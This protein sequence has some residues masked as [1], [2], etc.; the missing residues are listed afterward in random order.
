MRLNSSESPRVTGSRNA[1]AS[2]APVSSS[3]KTPLAVIT[4]AWIFTKAV[5]AISG[6]LAFGGWAE[7]VGAEVVAGDAACSLDGQDM[8][9]RDISPPSPI[10]DYVLRNADGRG[11]LSDAASCFDRKG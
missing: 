2:I 4:S 5:P 3:T 7:D 1:S 6:R 11:K 10:A 8:L 9:S